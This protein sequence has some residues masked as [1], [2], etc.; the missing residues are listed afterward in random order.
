MGGGVKED[1]KENTGTIT[2]M[3]SIPDKKERTPLK[4]NIEGIVTP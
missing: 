3:L 4:R 2:S 1:K